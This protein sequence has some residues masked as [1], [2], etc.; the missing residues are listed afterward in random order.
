ME[1]IVDP[2][3]DT[4]MVEMPSACPIATASDRD[5]YVYID[6]ADQHYGPLIVVVCIWSCQRLSTK[7]DVLQQQPQSQI[8]KRAKSGR[9]DTSIRMFTCETCDNVW[10]RKVPTRKAV[11][12]RYS[13][14]RRQWKKVWA[15]LLL[16]HGTVR[17]A[18]LRLTVSSAI[19]PVNLNPFIPSLSSLTT[20]LLFLAL[21]GLLLPSYY[22]FSM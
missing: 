21:A 20:S 12:T 15:I 4:T 5:Q 18:F 22:F 19:S 8:M 7:I 2:L 17:S 11:S 6:L 1:Y 9:L 3:L 14:R 10:W 16:M 13:T